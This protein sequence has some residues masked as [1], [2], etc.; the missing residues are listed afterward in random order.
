MGSGISAINIDEKL[1]Y[2]INYPQALPALCQSKLSSTS[3]TIAASA[4]DRAGNTSSSPVNKNCHTEINW[5]AAENPVCSNPSITANVGGV[6]TNIGSW[7]DVYD[8]LNLTYNAGIISGSGW[9]S[10]IR[11]SYVTTGG[12]QNVQDCTVDGAASCNKT[13]NI[14][15]GTTLAYWTHVIKT[16][17]DQDY[18]CLAKPASSWSPGVP[19]NNPATSC[20]NTCLSKSRGVCREQIDYQEA[21]RAVVKSYCDKQGT[22]ALPNSWKAPTTCFAAKNPDGSVNKTVDHFNFAAKRCEA[23]TCD[24][25]CESPCNVTGLSSQCLADDQIFLSWNAATCAEKYNVLIN[26]EPLATWGDSGDTSALTLTNSLTRTIEPNV[27]YGWG[28]GGVKPGEVPP[29]SSPVNPVDMTT[30]PY[31]FSCGSCPLP[32]APVINS[33]VSNCS[34]SQP[35]SYQITQNT[36]ADVNCYPWDGLGEIRNSANTVIFNSPKSVN[37][38]VITY[39][40][41]SHTFSSW[42]QNG[43]PVTGLPVLGTGDYSFRAL[44]YTKADA[45]GAAGAVNFGVDKTAPNVPNNF[46]S[47]DPAACL[48]W[49]FDASTDTGC[50]LLANYEVDCSDNTGRVLCAASV[51]TTNFSLNSSYCTGG[52][53]VEESTVTCKVRA[54]DGVGNKS[55]QATASCTVPLIDTCETGAPA[56]TTVVSPKGTESNPVIITDPNVTLSWNAS[57]DSLTD[58]YTIGA[59]GENGSQYL[60]DRSI[61][62]NS[63]TVS[64]DIFATGVKFHWQIQTKNTCVGEETLYW[65][66]PPDGVGWFMIPTPTPTPMACVL[67]VPT[68]TTL[69]SPLGGPTT[70]V[71]ITDQVID[72]NWVK[73][74]DPKT[75]GYIIGTWNQSDGEQILRTVGGGDTTS[76]SVSTSNYNIGTTYHWQIQTYNN[77]SVGTT[78][79]SAFSAMVGYFM[80]PPVTVDPNTEYLFGRVWWDKNEDFQRRDVSEPMLTDTGE[81][82]FVNITVSH[83]CGGISE[84]MGSSRFNSCTINDGVGPFRSTGLNKT[85]LTDSCTLTAKIDQNGSPGWY[86]PKYALDNGTTGVD[87]RVEYRDMDDRPPKV[88][89]DACL[90]TS[91]NDPGHLRG[92]CLTWDTQ[93]RCTENRITVTGMKSDEANSYKALIPVNVANLPFFSSLAIKNSEETVVTATTNGTDNQICEDLFRES[94]EPRMVNFEATV[95]H[96]GGFADISKVTMKYGA[97]GITYPMTYKPGSGAGTMAVWETSQTFDVGSAI[98]LAP[99]S[100]MV[101]DKVFQNSGWQLAGRNFEVWNCNV[102]ISGTLFDGSDAPLGQLLCGNRPAGYNIAY[103]G[104]YGL[105]F[106]ATSMTVT[107]P[108]YTS[109]GSPLTWGETYIPTFTGVVGSEPKLCVGTNSVS[110]INTETLVNPYSPSEIVADFSTIVNQSS[111]YQVEG[112]NIRAGIR[113]TNKIPPTCYSSDTCSA[114]MCTNN[115][116]LKLDN[117]IVEA[118]TI[119]NNGGCSLGTCSYGKPDNWYWSGNLTN[120]SYGYS[121]WSDKLVAKVSGVTTLGVGTSWS[122]IKTTYANGG[123]ALINGDLTIDED[124]SVPLGETLMLVV[125]G[126]V[127]VRGNVTEWSGIVVANGDINVIGVNTAQLVLSGVFYSADGSVV[128]NRTYDT[129]LLGHEADNNESPAVVIRYKPSLVLNLPA[130]LTK[131]ISGF[132]NN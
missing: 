101:E 107:T 95:G 83:T 57:T 51:T 30:T 117:G 93:G 128:I 43:T 11:E 62:T 70:P 66:S 25:V 96:Y 19:N 24:C 34:A 77:C 69:V 114:A 125:N 49:S 110:S 8:G 121:Y 44:N 123:I 86:F 33:P 120:K 85:W 102:N 5:V 2:F 12:T 132:T 52:A 116:T 47:T 3:T 91:D 99:I 98:D 58:V 60:W 111:W 22:C 41:K 103:A 84:T 10:N 112:G 65:S 15:S 36:G 14:S 80:V 4:T 28:V 29:Y 71:L 130:N 6:N 97:V 23:T 115:S 124:N 105:S 79:K 73:S 82:D 74:T 68:N 61:G 39:S 1:M 7:T 55:T 75:D 21:D 26:R 35:T 94:N 92:T 113:I 59:W 18:A 46:V 87:F 27:L 31:T 90:T 45:A 100:I 54:V 63:L 88:Y 118:P 17:S 64:R 56:K 37:D 20:T 127:E 119:T 109:G 104:N 40:E 108:T 42:Y 53:P 131:V 76:L 126:N 38:G 78:E 89:A 129:T 81:N 72:F 32:G 13:V 50:G 67:G 106:G 48:T 122:T 9:L 16:F